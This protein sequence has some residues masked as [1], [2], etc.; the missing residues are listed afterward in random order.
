M[1]EFNFFVELF[2][3][4]DEEG[5]HR[6]VNS[7]RRAEQA[8]LGHTNKRKW[9]GAC[10]IILLLIQVKNAQK[11]RP[12][13]SSAIISSQLKKTLTLYFRG[14]VPTHSSCLRLLAQINSTHSIISHCRLFCFSLCL[15]SS[16]LLTALWLFGS[17][18]LVLSNVKC[19]FA[20]FL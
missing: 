3:V 9:R 16:V 17:T 13:I 11:H 2:L 6:H 19:L 1:A 7:V 20:V 8:A 15:F 18:A 10:C 14:F 5:S 4:F 12:G